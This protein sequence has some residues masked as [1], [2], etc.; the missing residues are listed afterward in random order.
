MEEGSQPLPDAKRAAPGLDV[1]RLF[2]AMPHALHLKLPSG[3]DCTVGKSDVVLRLTEA[4]APV[5]LDTP[6][7]VVAPPR[8]TGVEGDL[9]EIP[10]GSAVLVSALVGEYLHNN[11]LPA[12]L[13]GCSIYSPATGPAHAV[14]SSTGAIIGTRALVRWV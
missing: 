9:A 3:A 6:V 10:P 4:E 8:Y 12:A 5:L 11:G 2:N 13:V 1:E 7:T 14:R